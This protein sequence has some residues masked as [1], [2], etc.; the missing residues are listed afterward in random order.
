MASLPPNRKESE[1]FQHSTLFYSTSVR[2]TASV[3]LR[4]PFAP[5]PSFSI[6]GGDANLPLLAP[7]FPLPLSGGIKLRAHLRPLITDNYHWSSAHP[8][9]LVRNVRWGVCWRATAQP[10]V[11]SSARNGKGWI[12]N[13]FILCFFV[14]TLYCTLF[15]F[16]ILFSP[17]IREKRR[18]SFVWKK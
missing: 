11:I 4:I 1:L 7:P 9:L 8:H 17:H 18:K 5:E 3:Q 16:L 2:T 15:F 6:T 14:F 10:R 12:R 13:F